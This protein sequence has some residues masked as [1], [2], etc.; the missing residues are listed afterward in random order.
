MTSME[1]H[2]LPK[3]WIPADEGFWLPTKQYEPMSVEILLRRGAYE[4]LPP[5]DTGG[6]TSLHQ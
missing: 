1:I 4:D 6:T 2:V 5:Q 3:G